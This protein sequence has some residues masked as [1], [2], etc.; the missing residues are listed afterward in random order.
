MAKHSLEYSSSSLNSSI[1][2]YD[3]LTDNLNKAYALA[4]V[5]LSD[6]FAT[7][8]QLVIHCYLSILSDLVTD[9]RQIFDEM[10]KEVEGKLAKKSD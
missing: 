9:I 5:A 1:N 3:L 2:S 4:M 6:H 8:E 10:W 7:C